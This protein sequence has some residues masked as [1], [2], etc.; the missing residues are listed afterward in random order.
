M[1]LHAAWQPE[2]DYDVTRAES[3]LHPSLT[4]RRS[5]E[6]QVVSVVIYTLQMSVISW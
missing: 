4:T 5:A 6:R 1:L 2:A 3:Y